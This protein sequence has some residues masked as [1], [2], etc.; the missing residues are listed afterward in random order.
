MSDNQ[1]KCPECDR[2]IGY[3]D[4]TDGAVKIKCPK[5]K[6]WVIVMSSP[7]NAYSIGPMYPTES[8]IQLTE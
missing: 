1:L 7:S 4:I 2:F 5:C 3:V 6:N 8:S